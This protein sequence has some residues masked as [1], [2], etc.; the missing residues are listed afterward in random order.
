MTKTCIALHIHST[1]IRGYF[2]PLF[3]YF[4]SPKKIGACTEPTKTLIRDP[5]KCPKLMQ[6][7]EL[8]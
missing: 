8:Q 7:F 6:S 2:A 3:A 1:V 5:Y 4:E